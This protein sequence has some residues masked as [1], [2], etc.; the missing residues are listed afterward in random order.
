M[1][2]R[3]PAAG[4]PRVSPS[5]D[6]RLEI[7]DLAARYNHAVDSGD[8]E[9]VAALFTEDG[10]IE[11]TATGT[12]A[13]RAAIAGYIGSRPDGWQRRR[14]LNSNA[15][16]EGVPGDEDAARLVLSLLVVSRRER[17]VPRLHGRYE[18]ELR[19]VDGEWR[20]AKRRII[21]DADGAS[22]RRAE[23]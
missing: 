2:Y 6:D 8:H 3:R 10:A 1:C 21:V 18:D 13:G 19:R 16:I 9:G 12:I 14:H 11:A 7:L 15:I 4:G 5:V 23:G 22:G 20:F 17:V